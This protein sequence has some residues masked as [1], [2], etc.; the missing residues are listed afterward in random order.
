MRSIAIGL[1]LIVSGP[2]AA[3]VLDVQK[4]HPAWGPN[5]YL[6]IRIPALD[7]TSRFRAGIVLNYGRRPLTF[8]DGAGGTHDVLD[9][10]AYADVGAAWQV[11]RRTILQFNMPFAL[12]QSGEA[13]G[14]LPAPE[15]K[16]AGDLSLDATIALSRPVASPLI[17]GLVP[18]VTLPTASDYYAGQDGISGGVA[19]AAE[20]KL[21]RWKLG[22][23]L[24]YALGSDRTLLNVKTGDQFY[25]R[26]GTL[27][28]VVPDRW[29]ALGEIVG[30][31]KTASPFDRSGNTPLEILAAL[32]RRMAKGWQADVGGGF[33]LNNGAGSPEWRLLLGLSFRQPET[34]TILAE[35]STDR[36]H[37]GILDAEDQCPDQPEDIDH[38][39][40]TDGCPDLDNDNDTILDPIDQCPD[41]YGDVD[42]NGCPREMPKVEIRSDQLVLSQK[43]FFDTNKATIKGR[44][45]AILDT[46]AQVL[47]GHPQMSIVIEGHTDSRGALKYNQDLS[48]LR[49]E[50]VV[51][52]LGSRDIAGTQLTPIGYGETR[53]IA[54]NKTDA[55]RAKNRRVMFKI[56]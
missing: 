50:A 56:R 36:D 31:T 28:E 8:V 1:M 13:F 4:F 37:D 38:Y 49:A 19:L 26:F 15:S 42:N 40:D 3:Q 54:S 18:S 30:T 52:Y 12:K 46:V 32:R 2:V 20:L 6:S 35:A 7:A 44:S 17:L 21:M 51:E 24:G 22:G 23:N 14:A 34:E 5:D 27:R 39:R 33:G 43:I 11:G 29:L 41:V 48:Q 55:G 45:F 10:Q 25:W 53:P 9:G 16:A 47:R